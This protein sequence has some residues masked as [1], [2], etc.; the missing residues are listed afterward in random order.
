MA[1]PIRLA[2]NKP[3]VNKLLSRVNYKNKGDNDNSSRDCCLAQKIEPQWSLMQ[4]VR[5][6]FCA[7]FQL[8]SYYISQC[9]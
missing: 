3:L 2:I 6:Y 5:L 4:F 1:K 9:W 7:K 8:A